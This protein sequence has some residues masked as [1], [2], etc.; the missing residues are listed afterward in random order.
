MPFGKE[1]PPGGVGIRS[2]LCILKTMNNYSARPKRGKSIKTIQRETRIAFIEAQLAAGEELSELNA[3]Y[4]NVETGEYTQAFF[5]RHGGKT[6]N[7][8][9]SPEGKK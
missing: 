4:F 8:G 9:H 2:I 5:D 7:K 6:N 1:I 3:S